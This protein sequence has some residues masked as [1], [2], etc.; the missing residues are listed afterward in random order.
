M[1][2]PLADP[3]W[4]NSKY[5]EFLRDRLRLTHEGIFT[6]EEFVAREMGHKPSPQTAQRK[7]DKNG[8]PRS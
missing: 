1:T 4:L 7:G 8:N 3:N 5:Q 2:K 6:F